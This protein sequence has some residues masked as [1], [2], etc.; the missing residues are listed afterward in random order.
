M[1]VKN[2]P[3]TSHSAV[4]HV[5]I[6]NVMTNTV[7]Q[8]KDLAEEIT[9]DILIRAL[10][11]ERRRADTML[12]VRARHGPLSSGLLKKLRT[13]YETSTSAHSNYRLSL[14]FLPT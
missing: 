12:K 3:G 13:A 8:K 6:L 1:D 2:G 7:Q 9:I 4:I 5:V 10:K 11:Q 14:N